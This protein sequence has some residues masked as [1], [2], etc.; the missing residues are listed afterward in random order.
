MSDRLTAAQKVSSIWQAHLTRWLTT[1]PQNAK[2]AEAEAAACRRRIEDLER[3]A[4]T[5]RS[6][7]TP[8]V[9]REGGNAREA[10]EVLQLVLSRL[11]KMIGSDDVDAPSSLSTLKDR[12][13]LRLRQLTQSQSDN[14]RKI[15]AVESSF[16]HKLSSMSRE[17]DA[18]KR[19]LDALEASVAKVNNTKLAWRAQLERKEDE[20]ADAKARH[21]D[22]SV[23]LS[24]KLA[25]PASDSELRSL[26]AR[27]VSAEKR[28]AT[29]SNQLASLH[30]QIA[31]QER[32]HTDATSKWEDRVK[33]FEKRLKAANEKVKAEKQG[34][35]E[36]ALQL[37]NTVK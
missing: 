14:E 21:R 12:L 30:A 37:E 34:G 17:L 35:K 3:Q 16:D 32:K 22:L 4:P 11:N 26:T 23:E 1:F 10:I 20:L 7:L 8:N 19:Q 33:E 29:L 28:V 15:K 36:R 27:A 6:V 31:D 18:K 2:T 9:R 5:N 13:L 24:D 25:S